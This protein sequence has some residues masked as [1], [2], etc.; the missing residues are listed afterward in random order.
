MEIAICVWLICGVGAAAIANSKGR[1]GCWWF[2]IGVLI[3]PLA[4]LI[5]GFMASAPAPVAPKQVAT[6]PA[7]STPSR[8]A[9]GDT[10][11]GLLYNDGM[12][13]VSRERVVYR[14]R[15]YTVKSL[16]PVSVRQA[17]QG[18]Y[19]IDLYN[20]M[21]R[22]VEEITGPNPAAIEEIAAAINRA[23]GYVAPSVVPPVSQPIPTAS[24]TT[25][26]P[27][28]DRLKLMAELKQMLDASLITQA[29]YDTKKAEILG[30]M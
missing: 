15:E 10:E 13:R 18:H 9:L 7:T 20:L 30:R 16:K 2:V 5:V 25:P 11:L 24:A 4:L 12:I 17:G 6:I 1:S 21:D 28:D 27:T 14:G 19:A 3:G 22:R 23:I 8:P 29:E 26:A